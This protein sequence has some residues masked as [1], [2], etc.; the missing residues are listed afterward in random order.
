MTNESKVV[1]Y[2]IHSE[3]EYGDI[4]LKVELNCDDPD[5]S[6]SDFVTIEDRADNESV[7]IRRDAW[8]QIK[9]KIDELF[10]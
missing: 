8:E 1:G 6:S 5:K 9:A 10:E 7:N 4:T 3:N 2:I